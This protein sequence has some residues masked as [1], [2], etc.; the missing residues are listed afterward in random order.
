MTIK[1]LGQLYH[2]FDAAVGNSPLFLERIS[3]HL[4]T[5]TPKFQP[6]FVTVQ[7]EIHSKKGGELPT[8]GLMPSPRRFCS[9]NSAIAW[10][11]LRICKIGL[12]KT[13]A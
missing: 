6:E 13:H 7:M 2:P 12:T 3:P 1:R 11:T 10:T 4:G 5:F 9:D 8:T